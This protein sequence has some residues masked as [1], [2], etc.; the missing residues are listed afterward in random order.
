MKKVKF[1]F[2]AETKTCFRFENQEGGRDTMQ[3]LYLK[4]ET[5]KEAGVEPKKGL[6]VT[7]GGTD[8]E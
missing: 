5:V 6:V 2:K 4:K 1:N 3:T 8:D 7:I